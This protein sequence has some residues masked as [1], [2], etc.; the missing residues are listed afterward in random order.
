[1]IC[2]CMTTLLSI[3]SIFVVVVVVAV[4]VV[5]VIVPWIYLWLNFACNFYSPGIVPAPRKFLKWSPDL[6]PAGKKREAA[7]GKAPAK[8]LLELR[9]YS[10]V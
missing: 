4:A 2:D 10:Q 8:G 7:M 3:F 9:N 1:M 5:V 6:E